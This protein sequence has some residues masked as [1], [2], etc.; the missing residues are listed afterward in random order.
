MR[1]H[2]RIGRLPL[3]PFSYCSSISATWHSLPRARLFAL[4]LGS[5]GFFT[6]LSTAPARGFRDSGARTVPSDSG[7]ATPMSSPNRLR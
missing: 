3:V 4:A 6:H 2:T 1:K 7:S 5:G